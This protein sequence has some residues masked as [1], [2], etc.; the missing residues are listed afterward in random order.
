MRLISLAICLYIFHDSNELLSLIQ[1]LYI[2]GLE[3]L[4]TV[5]LPTGCFCTS[6]PTPTP[7]VPLVDVLEEI[8]SKGTPVVDVKNDKSI[9]CS[10]S[11]KGINL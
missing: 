4:P 3:C 5:N 1:I 9:D 11:Q 2:I 8:S 6:G 10:S 7:Y